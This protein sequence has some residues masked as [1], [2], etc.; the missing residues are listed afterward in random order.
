MAAARIC[1]EH[2]E[3]VGKSSWV[4]IWVHFGLEAFSAEELYSLDW[5]QLNIDFPQR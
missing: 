4:L 5:S 1:A 3:M 2:L